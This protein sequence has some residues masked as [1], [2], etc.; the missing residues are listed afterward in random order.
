MSGASSLTKRLIEDGLRRTAS[1]EPL[2]DAAQAVE[3]ARAALQG[4]TGFPPGPQRAAGLATASQHLDAAKH[5]L[6]AEQVRAGEAA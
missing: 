5:L 1:A 6:A 2:I 4:A 3:A